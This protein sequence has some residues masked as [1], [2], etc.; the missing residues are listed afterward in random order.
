MDNKP[1]VFRSQ[2]SDIIIEFSKEKVNRTFSFAQSDTE[3]RYLY[4]MIFKNILGNILKVINVSDCEM[5]ILLDNIYNFIYTN[6]ESMS[7]SLSCKQSTGQFFILSIDTSLIEPEL[8]ANQFAVQLPFT[9]STQ[10]KNIFKLYQHYNET[11][12][13]ILSFEISNSIAE[14]ANCIYEICIQGLDIPE[15]QKS[16]VRTNI[17]TLLRPDFLL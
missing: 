16:E 3:D 6:S 8:Y 17:G 7:V 1:I 2:D 15:E 5:Y 11:L 12:I 14:F 9:R 4:T 13:S 10:R